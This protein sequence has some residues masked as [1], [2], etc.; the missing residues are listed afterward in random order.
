M[1][2]RLGMF[3]ILGIFLLLLSCA[4]GCTSVRTADT[5]NVTV[6]V[7][8][9]NTWVSGQEEFDRD[10]T[11]IIALTGDHVNTFNEEIAKNQ[12]DVVLLRANLA[13]DRQLLDR[14][15]SGLDNLTA[16]TDRFQDET[17]SLTFDDTPLDKVRKTLGV[18]TQYMKIYTI[19]RGNARQH[20][21]EYINN[22][23]V[24][25]GTDDPDY[26]NDKYRQEALQAKERAILAIA[27][28]DA[29]LGN[30]SGES[31]KLEELQ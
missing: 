10:V 31:K 7:R 6:S 14:W 2:R 17:T 20:L 30:L 13:K 28:G 5:H 19:S 3:F 15:G 9:Y 24:Y 16:A 23:E 4:A 1:N 18:M 25:I 26:W 8:N 27:E 21:I 29:A 12:P 11:S 22:A